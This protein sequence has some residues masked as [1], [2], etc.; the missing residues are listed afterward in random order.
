M[1]H[2]TYFFLIWFF[3][4]QKELIIIN[5]QRETMKQAADSIKGGRFVHPKTK[6]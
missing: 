5:S 4:T 3:L 1:H 6:F 2:T